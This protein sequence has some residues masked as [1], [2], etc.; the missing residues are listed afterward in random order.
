MPR[1]ITTRLEFLMRRHR[2]ELHLAFLLLCLIQKEVRADHYVSIVTTPPDCEVFVDDR[3]EGQAPGPGEEPPHDSLY[4]HLDPGFHDFEVRKYPGYIYKT[5][6]LDTRRSNKI[7]V[8]LEK[9]YHPP[10]KERTEFYV[11]PSDSEVLLDGVR[12]VKE[13]GQQWMG[14]G[15]GIYVQYLY[16]GTYSLTVQKE[17]YVTQTQELKIPHQYGVHVTL[18]PEAASVL[19]WKKWRIPIFALL[20]GEVLLLVLILVRR[21]GRKSP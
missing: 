16:P 21:S 3:Y 5:L 7:H 14:H 13:P 19:L 4:I 8:T 12:L 9:E 18:E 17:G 6:R 1:P 10:S 2:I 11:L 15:E 20:G